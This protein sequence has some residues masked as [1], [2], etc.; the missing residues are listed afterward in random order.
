MADRQPPLLGHARKRIGLSRLP[1][2]IGVTRGRTGALPRF[3]RR[4]RIAVQ[5]SD[6]NEPT[7][8]RVE[9][10]LACER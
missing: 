1:E 9:G 8:K 6:E 3:G 10:N 2:V 7:R 4:C 5:A